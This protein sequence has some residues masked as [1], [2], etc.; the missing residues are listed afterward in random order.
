MVP[1]CLAKCSLSSSLCYPFW[2]LMFQCSPALFAGVPV[3]CGLHCAN[4]CTHEPTLC[5]NCH[6]HICAH[7]V[8]ELPHTHMS[9]HLVDFAAHAHVPTPCDFQERQANQ[10]LAEAQLS[11]AQQRWEAERKWQ[12]A[13]DREHREMV[14]MVRWASGV[15]FFFN[16]AIE[17]LL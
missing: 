16:L 4:A 1:G 10:A 12:A 11:E 2:W 6:A 8:W 14:S 5:G 9:L 13:Q 7:T 17:I 3:P 15:F